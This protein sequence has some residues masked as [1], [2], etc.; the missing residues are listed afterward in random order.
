MNTEEIVRRFSA[1]GVEFIVIGGYAARQHGAGRL[2]NDFDVLYRRTPRNIRG[3]VEAISPLH[4]TP[5][6]EPF[7]AGCT[8]GEDLI[9]NGLNF[10]FVTD[11][12][13]LDCR[14]EIDGI[15]V[16]ED[17]RER[18]VAADLFGI[19]CLF[20]DLD[21][22]IAAK[23]AAGRPKDFEALP[24]LEGIRERRLASEQTVPT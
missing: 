21:A 20:L 19:R 7:D 3:L 6:F 18:T 9:R 13:S 22:L 15:G 8:F 14:G 5:R 11:A 10:S 23:Q 4:P 2:T 16:Y 1:H 24:E 12:G 17:A